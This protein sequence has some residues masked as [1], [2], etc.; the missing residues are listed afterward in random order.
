[1]R[2]LKWIG[3]LL[4][5]L[6]LLLVVAAFVLMALGASAADRRHQVPE[7]VLADARTGDPVRG[8][9]LSQ[10][11]ACR[12]CHGDRLQGREMID[13]P[14]FHVIAAN[15][16]NGHGGAGRIF[17]PLDWD[18]AVRFGVTPD[19]RA[20]LPMMPSHR[21]FHLADDD[22]SH[23]A[24]YLATLPAVDNI[25]PKSAL[26]PLGRALVG[27]RLFPVDATVT[28]P[29]TPRLATAPPAAPTAAYGA[30]LSRA[31]CMECHGDDLRGAPAVERGA[32]PG[33]S[34]ANASR[35]SLSEFAKALREGETPNG[36][37]LDPQY[38]PW[39][40]FSYYTDQEVEALYRHL[41]T[42]LP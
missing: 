39:Q 14:P 6:L 19:G 22:A 36:A 27:A 32:P 10:V 31:I 1:M 11:L 37:V 25:L 16:T 42:S 33:P 15:L 23:L 13:A 21:F 8:E 3:G 28:D 38:M 9:H 34:L 18:R 20:L 5:G 30:Y 17:G 41:E 2:V 40:S 7:Q 29:D 12:E 26:R 35:W 4:G 24:A